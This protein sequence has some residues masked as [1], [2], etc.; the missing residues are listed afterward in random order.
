MKHGF[1]VLYDASFMQYEAR[2]TAYEAKSFQTSC[3]PL[4]FKKKMAAVLSS[5]RLT[6]A[7]V[8]HCIALAEFSNDFF[9]WQ[10]QYIPDLHGRSFVGYHSPKHFRCSTAGTSAVTYL[11]TRFA[12]H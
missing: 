12:D 5:K 8:L 10:N 7:V 3:F 1:A 11:P 6:G 9:S 4:D 2:L